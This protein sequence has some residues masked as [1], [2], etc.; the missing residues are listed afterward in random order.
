MRPASRVR[1]GGHEQRRIAGLARDR[2]VKAC[3]ARDGEELVLR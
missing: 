1:R 3:I 2:G